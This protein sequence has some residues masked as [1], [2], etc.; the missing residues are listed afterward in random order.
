MKN[1]YI[2]F[3]IILIVLIA[4]LFTTIN[5][6]SE[7]DDKS[8]SSSMPDLR[9]ATFAGGCFWCMEPPFEKLPG[10]SK[11]I[12]GYTGGKKEN[13][14]YKEVATGLT[15]HAEAIEIH[16]DS[17]TISYND[18]LEVLWRNIDPTDGNGQFVD[19]GKQYRPAIFYHDQ[20]QKKLAEKS[21][22]KLEKSKRFKNK[23]KTNI[24][25]ATT[26]YAAEEYHQDFYK[27]S[28]IRYKIY[29]VGS[30]RDQFLKKYWGEKLE[31]KVTKSSEKNNAGRER[32][33]YTKFIK[34]PKNELKKQLTFLQYRVTQ[35]NGT[36]PPYT[37][38][39]W[40]NKKQGIYVDIVSGEPLFSSQDKFKSGTGWPSFTKPL[41][42]NNTITKKD[43]SLGMN[44]IEVKSRS[45]DSHLGHLFNDGP[46]PTGL[47]YCV[48]S[49][50]LRFIPKESLVGEGYEKFAST[51][52]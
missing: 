32:P 17:F 35:E 5:G 3:F 34:P 9:K 51:F 28:T 25:K 12:S 43:D 14:S 2:H 49:A 37:N 40:N 36:E 30:G 23:I 50:S 31:Y 46:K 41:I 48:N 42:P 4:V 19:R 21:R 1:N 6:S 15:N 29:R 24:V 10:V 22:S 47:R 39:Y 18:L 20:D 8:K 13:P 7:S 52:K 44:R 33:L 26:F 45:A 38:D 11:V 27:K 16:Y